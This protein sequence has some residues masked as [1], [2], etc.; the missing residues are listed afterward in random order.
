MK[1]SLTG[2]SITKTKISNMSETGKQKTIVI[3]PFIILVVVITL[4]S[5]C[6][7]TQNTCAAYANVEVKNE[8]K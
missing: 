1:Q 8:L 5:S 4:L 3:I 2:M 6:G 7:S